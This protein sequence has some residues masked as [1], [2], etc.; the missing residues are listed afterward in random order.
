MYT[1]IVKIITIIIIIYLEQTNY[2]VA[3]ILESG[4]K[5]KCLL[6][7]IVNTHTD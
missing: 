4:V 3:E 7:E 2:C 1:V 6:K 5:L